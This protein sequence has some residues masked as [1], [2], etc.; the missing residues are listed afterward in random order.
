MNAS[1]SF[2]LNQNL[3]WICHLIMFTRPPSAMKNVIHHDSIMT[4]YWTLRDAKLF[5]IY[6]KIH[7]HVCVRARASVCVSMVMCVY[8]LPQPSFIRSLGSQLDYSKARNTSEGNKYYECY[9]DFQHQ[10]FVHFY[11]RFK[12]LVFICVTWSL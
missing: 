10:S 12:K 3:K 11:S 7:Q 6:F 8:I 9:D 1:N 2:E 4:R 5:V